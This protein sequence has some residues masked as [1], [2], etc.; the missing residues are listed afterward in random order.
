MSLSAFGG[1]GARLAESRVGV[2][3]A[4]RTLQSCS[5][6]TGVATCLCVC[7]SVLSCSS[8]SLRLSRGCG[9]G[10]RLR[11][12]RFLC[13]LL[14]EVRSGIEAPNLHLHQKPPFPSRTG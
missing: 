5:L 3:I 2:Q 9:G 7:A 6:S 8:A 1:L 12:L 4:R 10:A 14:L 11:P 13:C